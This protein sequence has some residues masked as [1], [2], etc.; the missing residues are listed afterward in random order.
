METVN[1]VVSSASKMI[2]GENKTNEEPVNGQT[3]SGTLSE[4]Y[5]KG[6]DVGE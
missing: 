4:P 6:N 1:N 5:D 2:W 3:G